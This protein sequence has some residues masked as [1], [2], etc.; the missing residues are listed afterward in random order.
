[1]LEAGEWDLDKRSGLQS[2]LPEATKSPMQNR[3]L[4]FSSA[5]Q[6]MV[7][8]LRPSFSPNHRF[9]CSFKHSDKSSVCNFYNLDI[10]IF[11]FSTYTGSNEFSEETLDYC[12]SS[13]SKE[14]Y[15]LV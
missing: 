5:S 9:L 2:P 12:S 8:L 7:S 10:I 14:M 15:E 13:Q 1:M 6:W 3:F 4:P 11:M